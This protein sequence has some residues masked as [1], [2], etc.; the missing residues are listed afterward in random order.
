[1]HTTSWYIYFNFSTCFSQLCAHRQKNLLYLCD[2]GIFH[3]VWVAVWSALLLGIFIST[4]LHVSAN[5]VPITLYGW[6]SGLQTRQPP[7]HSEKCQCRIDTVSSSDD[8]HIVAV[9]PLKKEE[10]I[11]FLWFINYRH[12]TKY[13]RRFRKTPAFRHYSYQIL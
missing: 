11:D 10:K 1:V 7:V 9:E 6:L 12:E 2:T 5:Y 8:G 3:Y 4:S 13:Q